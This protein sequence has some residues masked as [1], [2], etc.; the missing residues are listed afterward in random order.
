MSLAEQLFDVDKCYE[1]HNGKIVALASGST[2]HGTIGT[3]V[4]KI[5]ADF[6][7]GKPCK[8][9]N[10][11]VDVHL[12]EKDCFIPDIVVSCN[13]DIVKQDGIY[14]APDLIVEILSPSTMRYD[15]IY[16]KAIYEKCG[17][18]EYWIVS[19][20]ERSIEVYLLQDGKYESD[21]VYLIYPDYSLRKMSDE[22]RARI[23]TSFSP[24]IF[25]DLII[26]VDDIF[27]GLL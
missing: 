25:P 10:G 13:Q 7:M 20:D 12:T 5:F 27:S 18:K 21:N 3:N 23:V 4:T 17:V 24:S 16:K 11:S 6:L 22:E 9:W 2:N 26:S 15:R 1:M 8:V 14:G 19:T